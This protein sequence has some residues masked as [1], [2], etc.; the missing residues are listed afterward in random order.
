MLDRLASLGLAAALT[1]TVWTAAAALEPPTANEL[2]HPPDDVGVATLAARREAQLAAARGWRVGHDFRFAD[3]Q[4]ESG[5]TFKHGIVDDAG[6]AYKAVHY[7]HGNGL[8]VADVDGDGLLDVYFTT[9]LGENQLWRNLGDGT[10]RDVTGEAGVGMR[11]RISVTASFADADNDGDADLYVT[12]VRKGNVLF[13]NDGKGRFRDVTAQSGLG[14]VGHSSGAVFFDYDRDGLLDLFLANVGVYTTDE[15]GRGG[16]YVARADA[17]AGHTHPER[18]EL[19]RLYRNLGGLRFQDVTAETG[20]QDG[21]WS[22][23]ALAVDFNRDLWP[24]LYVLNMQGHNH[25]WENQGGKRFADKTAEHFPKNPWGAMGI[26]SFDADND[27]LF[28]LLITDMHSDMLRSFAPDEEKRKFPPADVADADKH[29]WGNAFF[30]NQGNGRFAETAEAMG[31]ENYWPWG[32]SAADLNADGW[33]DVF[34]TASMNYP[35]RYGI[36][37][38]LL[39]DRGERFLD[40][41]FV[42]GV[43][44]RRDGRTHTPWMQFDCAGADRALPPCAGRTGTLTVL[45]TLGSR[46]SAVFDLDRD[47]DL[48]IVTSEL[49]SAPQVLVSDLAQRR[50]DLHWL[51]VE[52]R[53][54]SSNRDGLGAVVKVTAGGRTYQRTHDGK[55]GYLA[56]SAMPLYVGLGDA[57]KVEKV[58]VLWPSGRTQTMPGGQVKPNATL[59]LT[60]PSASAAPSG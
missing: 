24:D 23:D 16:Y 57:A 50:K 29:V 59:E 12:T 1:A 19:S 51:A 7:D 54:T 39:N 55:S 47:G 38:L 53:G 6:K 37:S 13:A 4:P 56:Q 26:A 20:L 15:V 49:N 40:A 28:D 34:I 25:Y 18:T 5:I 43:E 42:L 21:G 30:K 31:L 60:E 52:L 41:E 33:D 9:Q 3:R 14:Y 8:A 17:F 36:N 35:F 48:D 2:V 10:F 27:G 11:D 58:E 44:P 32:L 22:G 45:A 46:S